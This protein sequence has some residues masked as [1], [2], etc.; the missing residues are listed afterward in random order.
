MRRNDEDT[1]ILHKGVFFT[2][3]LDCIKNRN[4]RKWIRNL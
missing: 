1:L 3:E 4:E 2:H